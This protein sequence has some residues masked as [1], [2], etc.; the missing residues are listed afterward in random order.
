MKKNSIGGF[1]YNILEYNTTDDQKVT[2]KRY[3]L[4]QRTFYTW[5]DAF[6][7]CKSV[8]MRMAFIET[9]AERANLAVMGRRSSKL[10]E[11]KVFVG[12]YNLTVTEDQNSN[13]DAMP[14]YSVQKGLR[15][16]LEFRTEWC[17]ENVNKFMCEDVVIADTYE[18]IHNQSGTLFDVKS[19]FTY[20][21][22]F[23]KTL[24]NSK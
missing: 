17:N 16:K 14:C 19:I 2:L 20:I 1:L 10:F 18:D 11:Y 12:G 4:S 8:G 6:M 23:G 21:G 3:Y 15:R 9:D 7:V 24:E 13:S 22:S 5:I